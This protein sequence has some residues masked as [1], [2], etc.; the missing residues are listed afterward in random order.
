MSPEQALCGTFALATI[1]YFTVIT[2][3]CKFRLLEKVSMHAYPLEVP[4]LVVELKGL[5]QFQ[6]DYLVVQVGRA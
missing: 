5:K 6:V 1:K 4:G 2:M 3:G